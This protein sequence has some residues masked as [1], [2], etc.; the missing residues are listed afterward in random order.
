M[1]KSAG[2]GSC[3]RIAANSETS[4]EARNVF[5]DAAID[6]SAF[7]N[8]IDSWARRRGRAHAERERRESDQ[9]SHWHVVRIIYRARAIN[10]PSLAGTDAHEDQ[11]E[12]G[13]KDL[14]SV[15]LLRSPMIS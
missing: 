9:D 4:A 12:N 7:L 11:Q 15:S 10:S 2:C 1:S 3:D 14:F 13:E 5:F 6:E 8:Q